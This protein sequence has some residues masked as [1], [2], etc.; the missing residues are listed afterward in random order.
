MRRKR[1]GIFIVFEGIDGTGKSTQI[2]LLAGKLR[3][4]GH[5]VV[6]TREPTDGPFGK[7]IRELFSGR[8]KISRQEELDLFMADRRQH[9]AE[10]IIPGLA[11]NKIVLS[12]RYYL[13]TAAYQGAAGFDPLEI[14]NLNEV[15][16]PIP[17]LALLLTISAALGIERIQSLRGETL[18]AFEQEFE[19]RQVAQVFATLDYPYIRRIDGSKS[20]I[21]VEDAVWQE[22]QQLLA[23]RKIP[24]TQPTGTVEFSER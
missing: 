1:Q 11:A 24:V 14:I 21:E 23:T 7:K 9:V 5:E 6:V 4:M 13:S 22:V 12:D 10:V 16:A 18:N 15:F 20:I 8:E 19:L 2:Q 17:D 3:G